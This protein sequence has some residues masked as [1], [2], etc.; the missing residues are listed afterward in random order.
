MG[1]GDAGIG[2]VIVQ[3][4]VSVGLADG[5]GARAAVARGAAFLGAG[6]L[7]F[8]AQELQNAGVRRQRG[9]ALRFAIE[10]KLDHRSV[11]RVVVVVRGAHAHVDMT[12]R[13][14]LFSLNQ[15]VVHDKSCVRLFIAHR[16]AHYRLSRSGT[17]WCRCALHR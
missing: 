2:T 14:T 10:I 13:S 17:M 9:T 5:D 12:I 4:T 15:K 7:Q 3:A 16:R 11:H 6:S 8:V 1:R